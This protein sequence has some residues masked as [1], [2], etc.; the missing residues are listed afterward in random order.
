MQKT[1]NIILS[2]IL[3]ILIFIGFF[4]LSSTTSAQTADGFERQSTRESWESRP[5]RDQVK[6]YQTYLALA[7]CFSASGL[8]DGNSNRINPVNATEFK[9]FQ[10]FQLTK[11]GTIVYLGEN[12]TAGIQADAPFEYP[13]FASAAACYVPQN[14]RQMLSILGE[15][16]DSPVRTLCR[17]GFDRN[18]AE[19]EQ[20]GCLSSGGQGDFYWKGFDRNKQ[21]ETFTRYFSDK[22]WGGST[23]YLI[24]AAQYQRYIDLFSLCATRADNLEIETINALQSTDRGYKIYVIDTA[25]G[26]RSSEPVFHYAGDDIS[27]RRDSTVAIGGGSTSTGTIGSLLFQGIAALSTPPTITLQNVFNGVNLFSGSNATRLSCA[28][29][30]SRINDLSAEYSQFVKNA[31]AE[32]AADVIE[33]DGSATGV[34]DEESTCKIDGL[35]WLVC[36]ALRFMATLTDEAFKLVE[37]FLVVDTALLSTSSG[38]YDFWEGMRN[39]ANVAFIIVFLII[40]F[41]QLTSLGINNYG[42]KKTLPRLIIAAILVNISF[43]IC[44]LAVDLSNITGASLYS[45]LTS[46]PAG[47]SGEDA[48]NN[49]GGWFVVITAAIAA[50]GGALLAISIPVL[51]AALLAIVVILLILMVRFALIVILTGL[52]PL[53]FVAFLLPNTEHLFKKWLKLFTSMLVL[54]PLVAI[55]FGAS[56]VA[57]R[58]II[59]AGAELSAG[60]IMQGSFLQITGLAVAALPLL[61]VPSILKGS[62]NS[63]GAIGAKLSSMSSKANSRIGAKSRETSMLGTMNKSYQQGA[64][65]RRTRLQGRLG[66][67]V[68]GQTGRRIRAAGEAADIQGEMEDLKIEQ[69]SLQ[70]TI[71]SKKA[72]DPN[73]DSDK[74]LVAQAQ[75]KSVSQSQ[76]SA[77][78]HHLATNGRDKALR[79]LQGSVTGTRDRESLQRA[80]SAGGGALASKAPDL[81]KG[82]SAAFGSMS[83]EDLAGLSADTGRAYMAHLEQ[84]HTRA[85]APGATAADIA[86]RDKA[87]A[88]FNSSVDDIVLNPTLQGKFQ[89][90]TGKQIVST[91]G[92]SSPAFQTYASSGAILGI[93]AIQSD[94]K[95]R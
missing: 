50:G 18:N 24:P 4:G 62:L 70:K 94:G 93:A 85:I 49:V 41:S 35:G 63:A 13:G 5:L 92:S 56:Y 53:A 55:V 32:G 74:F 15:N 1:K 12:I 69:Q 22:F 16:T 31:V 44:Q 19:G 11:D 21:L 71:D 14:I 39:F 86:A 52:A 54:Y 87:V 82:P 27:L 76:R 81:V 60:D 25:T 42:V 72:Q 47:G 37:T 59:D 84:L 36:P 95:I 45:A 58:V 29:L 2:L 61:A 64:A 83:G 33:N 91:I 75:S 46:I 30:E 26:I 6:I 28:E 38:T 80:I 48:S 78:M 34:G 68:P 40:I 66:R 7:S 77:A 43:F 20:G 23:P 89:G 57:S 90:D 67:I 10:E 88:A 9:W 51:L 79:Q 73:F 65:R 17:L 3:P 8:R